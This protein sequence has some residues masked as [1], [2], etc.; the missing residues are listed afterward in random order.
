[1]LYV[2]NLSKNEIAEN[3]ITRFWH[4]LYSI[5]IFS[6]YSI[7][8]LKIKTSKQYILYFSFKGSDVT[9][10][11][12]GT[13][14]HVMRE[15]LNLAQEKLN[16]SCELIDLKTILPWDIETVANVSNQKRQN[17]SLNKNCL[18][19][20]SKTYY[21][22]SHDYRIRPNNPPPDFLLHFDLLLPT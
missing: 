18:I 14:V 4:R 21:S 16:V 7:Y 8:I 10:V 22:L 15:V 20:Y 11:A 6:I 19:T 2:T 12:W 5:F 3:L 9:M 17:S 1:M 13:Q